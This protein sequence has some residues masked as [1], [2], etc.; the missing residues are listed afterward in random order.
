MDP[1]QIQDEIELADGGSP[2]SEIDPP[3][4]AYERMQSEVVQV[5]GNAE[6]AWA[7]A[8]EIVTNEPSEIPWAVSLR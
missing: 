7:R 8:K 5:E 6:E 4:Y 3:N 2:I 1:D